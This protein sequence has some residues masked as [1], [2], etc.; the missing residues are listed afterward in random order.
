MLQYAYLNSHF[1]SGLKNLLDVAVLQHVECT[2]LLGIDKYFA[3]IDEIPFDFSRRRLS[4]VVSHAP[5]DNARP[6]L[7]GRGRG[8]LR[9]L[10]ALRARRRER[11]SSTRA[12]S[13]PPSR[14]PSRSTRTAS[15]SSPSPTRRLDARQAGY[16]V[17]DESDLTLL[18]YIA[19]L[20]PP[21][22]SA[23]AAIA[24]LAQTRRDGEDPHRRQRTHHAQDLPRGAARRRRNRAR[25]ASR[26]DERRRT[27]RAG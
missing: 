23:G 15:A 14:R 18:G 12:I 24:A 3:K 7:Q 27:G 8:S 16:S 26:E 25:P 11:A 21:K 17:A 19:F 5:T 1:Q 6:D 13:R 20:D 4:V 9:R 2:K 22:E 10:H